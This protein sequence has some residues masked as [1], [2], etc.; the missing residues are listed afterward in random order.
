[1]PSFVPVP[2][3]AEHFVGLF[4]LR[5]QIHAI[6]DL[7]PLLG[8]PRQKVAPRT[9]VIVVEAAGLM[10]ALAT[11]GVKGIA[12]IPLEAIE[13]L[14]GELPGLGCEVLSGRA[15]YQNGTILLLDLERLLDRPELVVDILADAL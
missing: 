1:L 7:R 3:L 14:Q 4:N 11:D 2:R 15:P 12:A 10:T 9:Q 6:T 5:G 13:P 8:L